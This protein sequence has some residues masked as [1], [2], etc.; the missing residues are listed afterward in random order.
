MKEPKPIRR[1]DRKTEE[2]INPRTP[3]DN[4]PRRSM[5]TR[6]LPGGSPVFDKIFPCAMGGA[7]GCSITLF[8]VL[9]HPEKVH[10]GTGGIDHPLFNGAIYGFSVGMLL[11]PIALWLKR[12]HK[13]GRGVFP[14]AILL[15]VALGLAIGML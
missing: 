7:I 12:K 13:T 14:V 5:S 11:S 2:R 6:N 9:G 3:V 10:Y 15:G 1:P 4:T 8:L